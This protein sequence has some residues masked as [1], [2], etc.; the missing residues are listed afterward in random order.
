MAADT[1]ICRAKPDGSNPAGYG[2]QPLTPTR[3]YLVYKIIEKGHWVCLG[4]TNDSSIALDGGG[5]FGY[6]TGSTCSIFDQ[7]GT[8]YL[9]A[10]GNDSST[11]VSESVVNCE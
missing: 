8:G 5:V 6:E 7:R 10:K 3:N 9:R 11:S 1:A 2:K 4:F